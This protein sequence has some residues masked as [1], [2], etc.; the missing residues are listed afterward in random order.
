MSPSSIIATQ[1]SHDSEE[2]ARDMIHVLH[3]PCQC[4]ASFLPRAAGGVVT[5]VPFPR[6]SEISVDIDCGDLV[7]GR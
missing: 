6:C 5:L 4:L 3:K 2:E 1:E 7:P